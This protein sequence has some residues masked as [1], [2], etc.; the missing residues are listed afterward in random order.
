M[1]LILLIFI[2]FSLVLQAQGAATLLCD[3]LSQGNTCKMDLPARST[4]GCEHAGDLPMLPAATGNCPYD[5][6]NCNL[7]AHSADI[8]LSLP[9]ISRKAEV[10]R[11]IEAAL[12]MSVAEWLPDPLGILY[13]AASD[14]P[15]PHRP[16]TEWGVWRL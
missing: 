1:R 16:M 12:N 11:A 9:S 6:M 5:C 8:L 13:D 10:N 14:A 4:C 7:E 2:S 15:P 3:C